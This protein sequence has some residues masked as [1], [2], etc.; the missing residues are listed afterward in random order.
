[1]GETTTHDRLLKLSQVKEITGLGKT[2]I[3]ALIRQQR[4]PQP[5]KPGGY[6]SRW[7]EGEIR[8]WVRDSR[9]PVAGE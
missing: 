6:A 3:Y 7:S 4:F 5:F 1:M 9:K 8:G 2:Q